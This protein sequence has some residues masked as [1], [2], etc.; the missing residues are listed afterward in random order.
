M[1]GTT[2]MYFKVKLEECHKNA[3]SVMQKKLK[4]KITTLQVGARINGKN[5]RDSKMT[6]IQEGAV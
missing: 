6:D 2:F 4:I 5:N 3:G 1:A